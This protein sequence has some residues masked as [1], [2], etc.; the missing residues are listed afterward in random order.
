M[1]DGIKVLARIPNYEQWKEKTG[2]SFAVSTDIGTGEIK[3]KKV[4]TKNHDISYW[5][6]G[7]FQTY[8]LSIVESRN[9]SS[10]IMGD[11]NLIIKGSLHKNY[12]GGTN[13]QAFTFSQLQQEIRSLCTALFL[14][15]QKCELQNIEI[16]VN[17]VLP[18][19][20]SYYIFNS[21]L[22]YSTHQFE[23][24]NPDKKG[25]ILG[26][27]AKLAQYSI[28][29]Y[30]KGLQNELEYNLMRFEKRYIKMQSLKK[31]GI[32]TLEDLLCYHKIEPLGIELMNAWHKVLINEP[33]IEASTLNLTP[34]LKSILQE[35]RN[36]DYWTR[37]RK[38]NRNRYNKYLLKYR[39]LS[40]E[41]SVQ[42]THITIGNLIKEAWGELLK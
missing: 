29:C 2:I 27:V 19:E 40:N 3:G 12:Y 18:F 6:T 20:T 17:V 15:P 5:H 7:Y 28:K 39:K 33:D 41:Y 21:V 42:K 34:E 1:I 36:R 31:R 32:H 11:Y 26:R 9:S 4:G 35:G 22:M 8:K 24:Y 30:D 25:I 37:L 16:G 10:C 38:T 13:Y 14:N 23:N